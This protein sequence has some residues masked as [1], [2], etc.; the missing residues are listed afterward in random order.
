MCDTAPM[1]DHPA[2]WGAMGV[3]HVLSD[4]AGVTAP[5]NNGNGTH[6]ELCKPT[7]LIYEPQADG[8]FRLVARENLVF[9]KAPCRT[10]P[11]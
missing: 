1:T 9:K 6:T 4:Q 8:S 7:V 2:E 3:H 5:P 10:C 11:A